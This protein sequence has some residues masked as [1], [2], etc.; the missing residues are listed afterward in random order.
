MKHI[1]LVHPPNIKQCNQIL[2]YISNCTF[3]SSSL[4]GLTNSK[5]PK[6]IYNKIIKKYPLNKG[7]VNRSIIFQ[8]SRNKFLTKK[9]SNCIIKQASRNKKLL[10]NSEI[11]CNC[12]VKHSTDF[13]MLKQIKNKQIH[14]NEKTGLILSSKNW[15][16]ET[17]W[18]LEQIFNDFPDVVIRIRNHNHYKNTARMLL[19]YL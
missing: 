9:N 8:L 5:L 14:I 4:L 12:L 10:S 7:L 19:K 1:L 3:V 17:L 15:K 16:T 13:Y 18:Y 11:I 2:K 6:S